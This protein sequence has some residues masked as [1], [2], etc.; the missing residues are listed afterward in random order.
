MFEKCDV[1]DK[2]GF[3]S[4]CVVKL[5]GELL[6]RV[7]CK[8]CRQEYREHDFKVF[9]LSQEEIEQEE[10]EQEEMD[11][12]VSGHEMELA[13]DMVESLLKD[14]HG[15]SENSYNLLYQ[16]FNKSFPILLRAVKAVDGRF[17]LS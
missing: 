14:E 1:C 10:I 3:V 13:H 17:Y 9:I 15:V 4:R 6:E 16:M 2:T 11:E 8:G 12:M 7:L 5:A